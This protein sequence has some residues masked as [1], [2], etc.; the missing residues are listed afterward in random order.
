MII[1]SI[2][3]MAIAQ[4]SPG[5]LS[6]A[7]AHLEGISNC[8]KCHELG[9]KI[10][11]E[12]CLNCHKEIN[13]LITA[14]KGYH[15]ANEVRKKECISCHS[16]HHGK[17]F[18]MVRFDED[19]FDHNLT[20][21]RLEGQHEVIDCKDCHKP[22]HILDPEIQKRNGTFLGLS[23]DCLGCHEDFHQNTLSQNCIECH[24]FNLF[25]PALKFNHDETSFDL[26][27]SHLEVDCISCHPKSLKAGREF[28]VFS[29]IQFDD[30][31]S[32]HTDPHLFSA[33]TSCFTCHN[34]QSFSLFIGKK[35]F[36]HQKTKFNLE[37][38]HKT[39]DCFACHKPDLNPGKVFKD[40]L[41]VAVN[42]C[43][44]CHDDQHKGRFGND[45]VK[46]HI[47]DSFLSIKEINDFDHNVTDFPLQGKHVQVDCIL[48]HSDGYS[49]G[50]DFNHCNA[51]HTDYHE[52][53]FNNFEPSADCIH[54]HT[55][56]QGFEYSTYGLTE[57]EKAGFKLDGAHLATPC[58]DCHKQ[59]S[60]WKFTNLGTDCISCHKDIHEGYIKKDYYPDAACRTCHKTDSWE[61]ILF[62]HEKT[63]WSLK[64][65]HN[66]ISCSSCHFVK[67]ELNGN[68]E[69]IFDSLSSS[70]FY[71]HKD[72]HRNQFANNNGL[73]SCI[74]CHDE[75]H[76]SP[77]NF[78][79]E[80]SDFPL[81]GRHA[82]IDCKACHRNE[83][84]E[85]ETWT[86][87]K[88]EHYR[89]IDCHQ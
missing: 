54:C 49:M 44:V 7:H 37:G 19:A 41:G 53:E 83:S 26:S 22:D 61:K 52:G 75:L 16:D 77:S 48:C 28:Q 42:D 87:Y 76:W 24:D 70:C 33:K 32:C 27:G 88:I 35:R 56:D 25:R 65:K 39:V 13:S 73:T 84:H 72:P 82:E 21:Y 50:V 3:M 58:F 23:E 71:C 9:K 5:P 18:D 40:N 67:S 20:G 10:S 57:H 80:S 14:N 55:P 17:N 43:K 46:C 29:D 69:Q 47:E 60:K 34:E 31:N 89:C 74:E 2:P 36:Q 11:E 30:C 4:I 15:A 81:K 64:G 1:L 38:A 59:G 51:C 85:N 63:G 68:I 62:D 8:T 86:V 66:D 78:D 12:K 45:C 79:H 6:S